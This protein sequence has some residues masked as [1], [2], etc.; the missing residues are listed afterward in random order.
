[1]QVTGD[2]G[3]ELSP[4]LLLH[5]RA[6]RRCHAR[7]PSYLGREGRLIP[8]IDRGIAC[9]ADLQ[10]PAGIWPRVPIHRMPSDAAASAYIL[11]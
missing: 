3:N 6:A 1:V 2:K 4:D 11:L 10:Q 7:R 8:A 5:F 9:L